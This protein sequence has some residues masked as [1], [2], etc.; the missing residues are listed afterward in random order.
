[1]SLRFVAKI[2]NLTTVVEAGLQHFQAHPARGK[3]LM[4][5]CL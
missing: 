1:M 2:V 4:G 3:Q 5:T